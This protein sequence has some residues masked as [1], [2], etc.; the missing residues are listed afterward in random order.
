M[1]T[2]NLL[3]RRK[4]DVSAEDFR[5]FWMGEHAR[6]VLAQVGNLGI[7]RYTKCETKARRFGSTLWRDRC[8]RKLRVIRSG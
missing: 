3:V 6:Q 7:G 1:I 2:L 5:A 8:S 4:P